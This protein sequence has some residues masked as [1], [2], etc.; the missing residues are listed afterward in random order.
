MSIMKDGETYLN[1]AE[2]AA[3]LGVSRATVD[4][5]VQDGRLRRYK[6]GIRKANY[7][8]Q[9]DLDKLLEIREDTED[10]EN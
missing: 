1:T 5:M 3:Y 10:S 6:Q 8:K 2:A 7:Y 9:S 4:A